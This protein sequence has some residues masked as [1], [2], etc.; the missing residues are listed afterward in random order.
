MLDTSNAVAT[1]VEWQTT[2][3]PGDIVRFAFPIRNAGPGMSAKPR[4]CLV[5]EVRTINGHRCAW[6][7][8]GTSATTT[9][10]QGYELRV[11]HPAD[12]QKCGLEKPTR[13]VCGRC[14]LVLLDCPDFLMCKETGSPV[15]GRLS[16]SLVTRLVRLVGFVKPDLDDVFARLRGS[17]IWG[18]VAI[19]VHRHN[20]RGR[21]SHLSGSV[22]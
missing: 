3:I 8:Y 7:G 5:L 9:S 22:R 20:R 19:Q 2:L 11:N 18:P 4:P 15:I 17:D 1:T 16:G 14:V 13:F 6:L 12:M 10:N 21:A